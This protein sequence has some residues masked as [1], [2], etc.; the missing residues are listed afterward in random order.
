MER[1]NSIYCVQTRRV[2]SHRT[3]LISGYTSAIH[4][5]SGSD[6]VG[7]C[8]S[9]IRLPPLPPAPLGSGR[10]RRPGPH[11][12]SR[13][14]IASPPDLQSVTQHLKTRKPLVGLGLGYR[15]PRAE[16]P[17]SWTRTTT[18]WPLRNSKFG[19]RSE[20]IHWLR[21]PY[22]RETQEIQKELVGLRI[23]NFQLN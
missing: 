23:G 2:S 9:E 11:L 8:R 10:H 15:P 6:G 16:E 5:P 12:C 13:N 18:L 21:V 14:S 1:C 22:A 20:S 7:A 17:G 19:P 3:L 4:S